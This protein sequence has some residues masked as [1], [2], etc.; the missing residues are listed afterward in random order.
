MQLQERLQLL[1]TAPLNLS[2]PLFWRTTTTL[3]PSLQP[4]H[5][6]HRYVKQLLRR[7]TEIHLHLSQLKLSR[8]RHVILFVAALPQILGAFPEPDGSGAHSPPAARVQKQSLC[9]PHDKP[10]MQ[11]HNGSTE[12]PCATGAIWPSQACL[13]ELREKHV[14]D[15]AEAHLICP[16]VSG[17]FI[18]LK[19]EANALL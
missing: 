16:S 8:C 2:C 11:R 12:G 17:L 1:M 18:G 15:S 4:K 9:E 7:V 6:K 10:S 14:R 3:P 13:R 5:S 19:G